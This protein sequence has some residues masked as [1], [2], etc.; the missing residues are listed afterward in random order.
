MDEASRYYKDLQ[1]DKMCKLM[2]NQHRNFM[3]ASPDSHNEILFY[4]KYSYRINVAFEYLNNYWNRKVPNALCLG[5]ALGYSM[6]DNS[7]NVMAMHE[8]ADIYS[9]LT[10]E[11][12]KEMES[13]S[14]VNAIY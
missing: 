14:T 12:R 13:M 11:M 6:I 3:K 5:G 9:E 10:I 1:Y 8:V 4:Q 7:V 2:Y